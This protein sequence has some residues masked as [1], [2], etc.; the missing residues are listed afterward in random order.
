MD[1][2]FLDMLHHPGDGDVLAVA[3]RV[4]VDL[5]RVAQIF[6]DQHRAVAGDLDGGDDI[7][8]ELGRPVDDLHR[9]PAEHVGGPGQHRIADPLGDRDRLLAASG[10]CRSRAA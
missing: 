1:P 8:L 4:D 9:P 2:R 7:I 6:V 3:D 5:D 10:R